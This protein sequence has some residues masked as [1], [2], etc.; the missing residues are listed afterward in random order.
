MTSQTVDNTNGVANIRP[1]IQA[2]FFRSRYGKFLEKQCNNCVTHQRHRDREPSR[3]SAKKLSRLFTKSRTLRKMVRNAIKRNIPN[4]TSFSQL[5]KTKLN[6][7]T[8]VLTKSK[9]DTFTS[10]NYNKK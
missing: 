10:R 9:K 6:H 8:H 7:K 1:H 3:I 4:K 2:N 5:I